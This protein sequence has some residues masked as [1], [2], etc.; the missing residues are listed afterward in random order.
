MKYK[1]SPLILDTFRYLLKGYSIDIQDIVRS[2]ILDDI[3]IVE[4]IEP[5][6][7]NPFRLD[8]IRLSLKEGMSRQFFTLTSGETIYKI[9]KLKAKNRNIKYIEDQLSKGVLSQKHIE[10]ILKWVDNGINI[11]KLDINII[12]ETLLSTFDYGLSSGFDMSIFNTGIY[13]TQDYLMT[14]LHL[15]EIGI[16]VD[17]FLFCDWSIDVLILIQSFSKFVSDDKLNRISYLI[18]NIDCNC[19]LE[20]VKAAYN[21]ARVGLPLEELMK[22]DKD[23]YVYETECLVIVYNAYIKKLDYKKLIS[24][25]PNGLAKNMKILFDEMLLASHKKISGRLTK[26]S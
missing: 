23:S 17:S 8:Q 26:L 16:S 18:K 11:S 22:K 4:Y 15:M 5:C 19:P 1:N 20:R 25:C 3:D 7:D 13:Y 12:P 21:L 2:A 9:R 24:S 14:C 10:Y 6:K